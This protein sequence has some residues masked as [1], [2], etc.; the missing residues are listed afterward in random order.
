[1][2]CVSH[3]TDLS[4]HRYVRSVTAIYLGVLG[5][6]LAADETST[7]LLAAV[8]LAVGGGLSWL[9]RADPGELTREW[10]RVRARR[11]PFLYRIYAVAGPWLWWAGAGA[12]GGLAVRLVMWG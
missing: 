9:F 11:N 3:L 7:L 6:F 12:I 5:G 4:S 1:M 8:G 10:H 2:S